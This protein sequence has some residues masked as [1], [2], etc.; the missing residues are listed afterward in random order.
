MSRQKDT[1]IPGGPYILK[2]Q[3]VQVSRMEFSLGDDGKPKGIIELQLL[4]DM[5]EYWLRIALGHLVVCERSMKGLEAAWSA[6]DGKQIQRYL[7]AEF[8]SGMQADAAAAIAIDAFYASVKEYIRVP[9]ATQGAW[10]KSGTA[11][12]RV[13][14]QTLCLGFRLDNA[15]AKTLSKAL[16]ERFA[17]RDLAVHPPGTYKA[18]ML[19]PRFNLAMEWR[20]PTFRFEQAKP[21][22]GVVLSII[23]QLIRHPKPNNPELVNYCNQSSKRMD[24]LVR[25]WERRYGKL[26]DRKLVAPAKPMRGTHPK[27]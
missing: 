5:A 15:S 20:F 16:K 1:V 26:F 13:I 4:L 7:E 27:T 17:L 9:K 24:T 22:V 25:K 23:A 18:P 10:R 6:N 14:T 19:H 8:T 21:I 2:G 11:R 3:R 12:H